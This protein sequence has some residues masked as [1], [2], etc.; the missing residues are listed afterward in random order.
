MGVLYCTTQ[1]STSA[2]Q[3]SPDSACISL[4][5][6]SF[7]VLN[8]SSVT[9]YFEFVSFPTMAYITWLCFSWTQLLPLIWGQHSLHI[10][11]QWLMTALNF[12]CYNLS[13]LISCIILILT[14]FKIFSCASPLKILSFLSTTF[15][16]ISAFFSSVKLINSKDDQ[17]KEKLKK[18]EKEGFF[19]KLECKVFWELLHGQT[20]Y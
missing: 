2:F 18:E 1:A 19:N 14:F 4:T 16:M 9:L 10:K 5:P 11:P 15:L 3:S 7:V 12:H 17:V 8:D 20:F 6:L 13:F